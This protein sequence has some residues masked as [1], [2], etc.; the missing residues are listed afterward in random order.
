MTTFANLLHRKGTEEFIAAAPTAIILTTKTVA[1]VGGTKTL[2]ADDDREPQTFRIIWAPSTGIVA[3]AS[4][5][6]RRFDF[7][8]VGTY[9][10][11]V[12][13]GDFWDVGDQHNVVDYIF[14]GNGYEVKCGGTSFG[15]NPS[16]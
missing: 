13:I 1:W 11:Q 2:S 16:G 9:D 8:L 7:I 6:T 4:E 14:P 10:A 5:T 3:T 12:A 15:D